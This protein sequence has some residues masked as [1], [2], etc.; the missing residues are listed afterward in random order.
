MGCDGDAI[1]RGVLLGEVRKKVD[2]TSAGRRLGSQKDR[3]GP[4]EVD[5]QRSLGRAVHQDE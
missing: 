4:E 3:S 2:A 5:S 1:V